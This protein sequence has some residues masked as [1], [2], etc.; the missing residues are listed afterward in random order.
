MLHL[1]ALPSFAIR[2]VKRPFTFLSL[3][4]LPPNEPRKTTS[5]RSGA[6]SWESKLTVVAGPYPHAR[7]RRLMGTFRGFRQSRY[8]SYPTT[9]VANSGLNRPA[10]CSKLSLKSACQ[11]SSAIPRAH[12]SSGVG[13]AANAVLPATITRQIARHS[14]V[15]IVSSCQA[16]IV[17]VVTPSPTPKSPSPRIE[18]HVSPSPS[19]TQGGGQNRPPASPHPSSSSPFWNAACMTASRA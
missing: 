13:S 9:V 17:S 11:K 2:I 3:M 14:L 12:R 4:S 8:S 10:V 18:K 7:L 1:L 6:N 15:F 19:V 16:K 5:D